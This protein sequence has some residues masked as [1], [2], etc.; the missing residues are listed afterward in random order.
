MLSEM[1]G[2]DKYSEITSEHAIRGTYCDLALMLDSKIQLLLEA[3]A[4]GIDLN[5]SHVKQVVDYAA[6]KG[7]DWVVLTNG[8]HWKIFKVLF[9]KPINQELVYEIDFLSL[10]PKNED[11]LSLIYV[12]TKEGWQKE[13]LSDLSEQI[14]VL[15]KYTIAAVASS[16]PILDAIRRELKHLSP[17]VKITNE[18]IQ[19]ILH[20][21]IFKQDAI[22]GE[23]AEEVRK[24]IT[25]A[26]NRQRARSEKAATES[27]EQPTPSQPTIVPTP[28]PSAG[29]STQIAPGA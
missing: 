25:R 19:D 7:V 3:K 9:E 22:E 28:I 23:R 24:K 2:Y 10:D 12:L 8:V 20:Q 11:H 5:D 29:T 26:I 15:N 18:Q 4:I 6:N 21:Q 14:E 17:N 27:A 13:A 16:E 1:F